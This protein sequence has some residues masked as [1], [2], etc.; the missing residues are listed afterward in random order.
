LPFLKTSIVCLCLLTYMGVFYFSNKHLPI[1]STKVFNYYYFAALATTIFDAITLFTI[2]NLDLVPESINLAAHIIY[3]LAINVTIFFNFQYELSLLGKQ[4]KTD[5]T[6]QF[7]QSIPLMITSILILLLP[8][9]Y[10]EGQYT[11]YSMGP[12]V[13]ALLASVPIF[14]VVSII[15]I[16][17]PESLFVLVYI[18]LTAVGLLMSSEN[19]EKYLDKQT[20][21][22]NQ[23]ALGII[24]SEYIAQNTGAYATVISLGETEHIHTAIDWRYYVTILGQLR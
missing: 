24:C 18:I 13:Y 17:L 5:K 23:Y 7:L 4:I 6:V 21:M 11:N 3:M 2:N 20:G 19:S 8:L 14:F 10:I 1:I 22:F 16:A 15:S 12:K 9:D